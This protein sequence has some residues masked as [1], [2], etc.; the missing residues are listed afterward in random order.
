MGEDNPV[1]YNGTYLLLA[2]LAVCAIGFLVRNCNNL[3]LLLTFLVLT[4]VFCCIDIFWLR[5][6]LRPSEANSWE[7]LDTRYSLSLL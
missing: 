5:R 1:Y 3:T 2:G 4:K 7:Q 6:S